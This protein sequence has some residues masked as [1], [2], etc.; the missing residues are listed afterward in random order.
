MW[1]ETR[2]RANL[3]VGEVRPS[4]VADAVWSAIAKNRVEVDVGSLSLRGGQ[5]VQAL[6]PGLVRRVARLTGASRTAD[7]A[8]ERQRHKR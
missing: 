2:L 8:A 6:A 1:A 3:L 5:V 7:D 4:A